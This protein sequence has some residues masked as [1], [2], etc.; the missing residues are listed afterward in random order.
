MEWSPGPGVHFSRT[1]YRSS[2]PNARPGPGMN[3]P[4]APFF[5]TFSTILEGAGGAARQNGDRGSGTMPFPAAFH[6]HFQQAMHP[7]GGST[8]PL[9]EGQARHGFAMGGSMPATPLLTPRDANNPQPN[10][11]PVDNL[12][13]LLGT[14]IRGMQDMQ[15]SPAAHNNQGAP[16][17]PPLHF[18]TQFLNPANAQHGD[19]VYTEEALDRIITQ[20]MDAQNGQTAPGPAS[21]AAIAALPKK[22]ADKSILGQ[23]GKAE[24][25]VCM[26]NVS[27][28]DEVTVLPCS[29]WFHGECV[30]AWLKEHD[31]CPHCRQGIMAKD[32]GDHPI[33]ANIPR[34]PGQEPRN[35]QAPLSPPD[36][37]NGFHFAWHAGS[38]PGSPS[39]RSPHSPSSSRSRRRSAARD[40][41]NSGDASSS[42][43]GNGTGGFTGWVR[44]HFGGG[45]NNHE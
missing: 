14:L 15:G 36:G 23:E 11:F 13:G 7:H 18:F 25:S 16:G 22:K 41:R 29:H 37:N 26:D 45:S 21:E 20:F 6:Q 39:S 5:Q 34:Q 10:A 9:Q 35:S 27:L 24:C 4:F 28:G 44:S 17:F 8:S 40:M 19:A 2:S 1:S 33:S 38:G 12:Q 43:S 31:T 3:D 30:G 42:G 32:A